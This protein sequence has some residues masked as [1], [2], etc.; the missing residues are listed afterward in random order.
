MGEGKLGSEEEV[1][2]ADCPAMYFVLKYLYVVYQQIEIPIWISW[3]GRST[4]VT[5]ASKIEEKTN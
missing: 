1:V 2:V 3:V 4:Q 5:M